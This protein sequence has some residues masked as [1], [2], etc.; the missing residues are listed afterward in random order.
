[1]ASYFSIKCWFI[2]IECDAEFFDQRKYCGINNTHVAVCSPFYIQLPVELSLASTSITHVIPC[3][4]L[5]SC[6]NIDNFP[7]AQ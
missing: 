4:L 7:S 3:V 2:K 6:L 1:M 5:T